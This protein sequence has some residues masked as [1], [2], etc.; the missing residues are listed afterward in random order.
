MTEEI[1]RAFA[2]QER[3][4]AKQNH[5]FAEQNHAH[6]IEIAAKSLLLPL[7]TKNDSLSI[8]ENW[9]IS[10]WRRVNWMAYI[11]QPLRQHSCHT[12]HCNMLP[13]RVS[14]HA[15]ANKNYT[16]IEK[17]HICPLSDEALLRLPHCL[18]LIQPQKKQLVELLRLDDGMAY[19]C[20]STGTQH[21]CGSK[22]RCNMQITSRDYQLVCTLTGR[23]FGPSDPIDE[24]TYGWRDTINF[25]T[26]PAIL[27]ESPFSS[28]YNR[29][30]DTSST[31]ICRYW[32]PPALPTFISTFE[33]ADGLVRD[34]C[35][36]GTCIPKSE[37]KCVHLRTERDTL[38][39]R[40]EIMLAHLFSRKVLTERLR[41]THKTASDCV[42]TAINMAMKRK[43]KGFII[44]NAMEIHAHLQR[45]G[46]RPLPTYV[47]AVRDRVNFVRELAQR[48]VILYWLVGRHSILANFIEFVPSAVEFL[49]H[50]LNRARTD[51]V[52]SERIEVVPSRPHLRYLPLTQLCQYFDITKIYQDLS[53]AIS[54]A[55]LEEHHGDIDPYQ[56]SVTNNV[57]ENISSQN[58]KQ[59]SSP[60]LQSPRVIR[61]TIAANRRN[62]WA[63]GTYSP[64]AALSSF[65]QRSLQIE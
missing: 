59:H 12:E 29:H 37:L 41:Q 48:I 46:F 38:L 18:L 11:P 4:V 25:V 45:R 61:R 23:E 54:E 60:T 27:K 31:R 20:S 35:L 2:D 53:R 40:A 55:L 14:V 28:T 26:R 19:I 21:S 43:P 57:P 58:D 34:I 22:N 49:S 5:A 62:K 50:G 56:F 51:D 7:S 36:K 3:A 64:F 39:V 13:V 24:R 33:E 42:K 17:L 8:L 6:L 47:V 15:F 10:E 32:N 65:I 16:Q 44:S 52:F 9:A 1:E 63:N 30:D